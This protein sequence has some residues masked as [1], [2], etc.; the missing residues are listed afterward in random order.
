MG[1][2]KGQPE[3]SAS[4]ERGYA[5]LP[6]VAVVCDVWITEEQY[7]AQYWCWC[8]EWTAGECLVE[9]GYGLSG[10]EVDVVVLLLGDAKKPPGLGEAG[11]LEQWSRI[12][13]WWCDSTVG[14]DCSGQAARW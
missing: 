9:D 10:R 4:A 5:T 8:G 3:T 1:H 2:L 13:L 11:D 12:C 14:V 7:M 6:A